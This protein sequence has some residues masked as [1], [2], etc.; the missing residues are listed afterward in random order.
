MKLG[1]YRDVSVKIP[2]S[3]SKLYPMAGRG[4]EKVIRQHSTIE[5]L[6]LVQKKFTLLPCFK[7]HEK[8]GRLFERL[9][10]PSLRDKDLQ[11]FC[12]D[13]CL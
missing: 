2:Q 6:I 8:K 4:S 1:A 9:G 10:H 12:P 3:L 5:P 11:V 13:T 7:E